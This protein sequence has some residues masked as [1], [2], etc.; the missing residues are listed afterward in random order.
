MRDFKEQ[1][2]ADRQRQMTNIFVDHANHQQ[3]TK[4]IRRFF[5]P[6]EG[7]VPG[8]GNICALIGESRTGKTYGASEVLAEYKPEIGANGIKRSVLLVDSPI[9]GGAR[10]VLDSIASGLGMQVSLRMTNSNLI[11]A[12]LRELQRSEVQFVI[13][14]EAQELFPEKN[15][16]VLSFSRKLLRKMLNL[17]QF[18]IL[19]IGLPETYSIIAEDSQLIGRGGLP[20]KRLRPY[21]WTDPVDCQH[22]R[23]L[24]HKFDEEMPFELSDFASMDFSSR[25]FKATKGCI[26]ILKVYMI[27]AGEIALAAGSDRLELCHFAEAYDDRKRPNEVF[28]PFRNDP[29]LS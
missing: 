16:K 20:Y 10:A 11:L 19:C 8:R 4:A 21:D 15:R 9:E 1:L 18:N 28:N 17:N 5:K 13:F 14:D 23:V 22:F 24:C 27:A 2:P 25:L 29:S 7:G 6:V 12:I 3:A 26:G